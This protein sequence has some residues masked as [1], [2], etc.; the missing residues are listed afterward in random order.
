M[1]TLYVI[2]LLSLVAVLGT[3]GVLYLR[4]RRHLRASDTALRQALQEVKEEEHRP[5]TIGQQE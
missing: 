4:V 2:L 1:V 5:T 3:A